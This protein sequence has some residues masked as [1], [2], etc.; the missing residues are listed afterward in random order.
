MQ[1]LYCISEEIQYS[2]CQDTMVWPYTP[3]GPVISQFS[4]PHTYCTFKTSVMLNTGQAGLKITKNI[5]Q[6]PFQLYKS[7]VLN[8]LL[9]NSLL[10]IN[11]H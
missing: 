5:T 11:G 4:V 10:F 8:E 3:A 1:V 2:M 7:N 9:V 6:F